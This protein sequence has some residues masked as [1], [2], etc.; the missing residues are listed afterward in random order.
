MKNK[1]LSE[2][3]PLDL[4]ETVKNVPLRPAVCARRRSVQLRRGLDAEEAVRQPRGA[5]PKAAITVVHKVTA[6][7]DLIQLAGWEVMENGGQRAFY[8]VLPEF[9]GCGGLRGCNPRHMPL[10][11]PRPLGEGWGE[12]SP[13]TVQNTK[14]TGC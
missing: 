14:Q 11:L 12:G 5:A 1:T 10:F 8:A 3:T 9:A 7:R 2:H 6:A 13:A 4:A